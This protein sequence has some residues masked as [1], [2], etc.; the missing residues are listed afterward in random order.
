MI[1]PFPPDIHNI[2][3]HKPQELGSWNVERM[4][5]PQTGH[6]SCVTCH[7]TC[8]GTCHVSHV[9]CT[10]SHV[11][12]FSFFFMTKCWSLSVE[13]LLSTGPTP[14]SLLY[15]TTLG[16]S[17]SITHVPFFLVKMWKCG[18]KCIWII[19]WAFGS[20]V[21]DVFNLKQALFSKIWVKIKL[22]CYFSVPAQCSTKTCFW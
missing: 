20:N 4:F 18:F 7:V 19:C 8:H 12:F 14:S 1:H 5:T 16:D 21:K 17:G 3:N 10:V 9:T 2:I 15:L 13:G 11:T 6:M 22:F